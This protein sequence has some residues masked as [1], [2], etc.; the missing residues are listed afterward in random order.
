M[1]ENVLE[2]LFASLQIKLHGPIRP[3]QSLTDTLLLLQHK[4]LDGSGVRSR[5]GPDHQRG[6]PGIGP[7]LHDE[8]RKN[9]D[10]LPQTLGTNAVDLH[11]P[12]PHQRGH[13]GLLDQRLGND[14]EQLVQLFSQLGSRK[15]YVRGPTD[16]DRPVARQR[17]TSH[18][19]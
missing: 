17:V 7:L 10:G 12:S 18:R 14:V 5:H 16:L 6:P 1:G 2:A 9:L 3:Q 4:G 13:L 8:P 15:R 19:T 11:Q